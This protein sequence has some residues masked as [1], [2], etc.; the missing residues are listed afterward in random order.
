[1]NH[2]V[3]H[4]HTREGQ[5][6]WDLMIEAG[7]KLKTWRLDNPPEKL[8]TEKTKAT[9]IFDHDKK[10]LTY[11]GPVNNDKGTV[12]IVDEGNCIIE[13]TIEN[14]IKII[15]DGKTVKGSFQLDKIKDDWFIQQTDKQ[16]AKKSKSQFSRIGGCTL[17]LSI[18][19]ITSLSYCY[20]YRPDNF[21]ALTFFPPWAWGL[22]G[23]VLAGFTRSVHKRVYIL[24]TLCWLVF[25]FCFAEEPKSL[26][27][28]LIISDR[29][30][31]S[32]PIENKLRVVSLNCAGGNLKAMQEIIPYRP[33]VVLL[34]ETPA[35]KEAVEMLAQQLFGNDATIAY[36]IDTAIIIKGQ[37]EHIYFP[38][39]KNLFITQVYARLK[40][41]I[42][43]E[44][45]CIRLEPPAININLLSS[46]CW[47]LHKEDRID[48]RKQIAEITEQLDK[49]P[50]SIPVILGGDFNVSAD[51]SS[52][53]NLKKYLQDTFHNGGIG[54]G[55][56]ALN[57]VPLFRV[58]Q[59]W[60][61]PYFKPLSV[62][63]RKTEYSDHRMV[64]CNLVK[65]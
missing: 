59:I 58:D 44:I 53:K 24:L 41:G 38:K 64:I 39:P 12:E 46:Y 30:W 31:D 29:N 20:V 32:I 49:L 26:F 55:H 56:T 37:L 2:F 3:I 21:A 7:D 61:S 54:W 63:S 1:M 50:K 51:D 4:K 6:H 11:Q 9:P 48:R 28:G 25:I 34:Q 22:L 8:A 27:R 45:I 36:D 14:D 57:T 40:S 60:A 23:I 65:Q 10:F 33:D 47:K 18:V 42:E 43:T 5:V 35:K 13:S 15:F 17:I 19:L 16:F 62:F 52:L